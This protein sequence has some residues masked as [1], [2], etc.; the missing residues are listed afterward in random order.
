[1]NGMVMRYERKIG[2]YPSSPTQTCHGG[3]INGK[4]QMRLFQLVMCDLPESHWVGF[5][6]MLIEPT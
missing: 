2:E 3:F 5:M 1:M 6:K 4:S